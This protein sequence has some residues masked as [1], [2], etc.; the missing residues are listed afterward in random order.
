MHGRFRY[1]GL[2]TSSTMQL[3]QL[4]QQ[5]VGEAQVRYH[6]ASVDHERNVDRFLLLSASGAQTMGLDDV[7]VD[8]IIAA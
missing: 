4:F 2:C 1:P 8:A 7:V 6:N 5:L 3:I